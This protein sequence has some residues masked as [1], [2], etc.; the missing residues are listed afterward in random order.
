M[1]LGR[2]RLRQM[3]NRRQGKR[4]SCASTV[5][6]RSP[7]GSR[8]ALV[9]DVSSSGLFLLGTA[10]VQHGDSVLIEYS[11][12]PTMSGYVVRLDGKGF[13]VQLMEAECSPL[14]YSMRLCAA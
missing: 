12:R 11:G 9:Q 7:R 10:P 4:R 8:L 5:L 2:I 14:A 3:S 13:A 6:V 1:L